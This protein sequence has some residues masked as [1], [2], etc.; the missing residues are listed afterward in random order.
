[1]GLE[2]EGQARQYFVERTIPRSYTP[3]VEDPDE[4][5]SPGF[6][7][8][9]ITGQYTA[10]MP[11]V[12]PD[13]GGPFP[14]S[15]TIKYIPSTATWEVSGNISDGGE[16]WGGEFS[17]TAVYEACSGGGATNVDV[18]ISGSHLCRRYNY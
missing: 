4:E 15:L 13:T 12:P 10:L 3:D 16:G 2:L 17:G 6:A 7:I 18:T 1:M 11:F 14:G 9:N 5:E 8:W